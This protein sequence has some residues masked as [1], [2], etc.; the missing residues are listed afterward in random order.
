MPLDDWQFWVVTLVALGGLALVV[1]PLLPKKGAAPR[2]GSC[3]TAP[4]S[5]DPTVGKKTTLTIEG[6]RVG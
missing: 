6:R 5:G 2:C 1:R 3:P 4:K